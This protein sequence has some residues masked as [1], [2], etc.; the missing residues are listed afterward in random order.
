MCYKIHGIFVSNAAF[1]NVLRPY[2][3][4]LGIR[5]YI[6][7]E[8]I[9]QYEEIIQ[10]ALARFYDCAVNAHWLD[11][12]LLQFVN[13]LDYKYENKYLNYCKSLNIDQFRD[14][15]K[16]HKSRIKD[17]MPKRTLVG[18]WYK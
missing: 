2:F 4:S 13:S 3:N 18:V 6:F 7:K 1:T 15:T 14:V 5:S 12:I 11:D 17:T 8:D 10:K 9:S 16:K